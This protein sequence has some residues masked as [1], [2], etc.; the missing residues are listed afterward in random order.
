MIIIGE[1]L[2]DGMISAMA[3]VGD[4]FNIIYSK[5]SLSS[6]GGR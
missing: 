1:K 3:V 6:I 5:N 4:N 2:N